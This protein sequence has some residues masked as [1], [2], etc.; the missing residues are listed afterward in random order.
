MS[1]H[2]VFFKPTVQIN[3]NLLEKVMGGNDP[4]GVNMRALGRVI[5]F[6]RAFF[7]FI[8]QKKKGGSYEESDCFLNR[9]A[10]ILTN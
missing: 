8:S 2:I 3:L 7:T 1:N 4:E 6:P 9:T 5:Y 10:F